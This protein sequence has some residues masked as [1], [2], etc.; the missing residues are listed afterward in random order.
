MAIQL[1]ND[2]KNYPSPGFQEAM[3][4]IY[5][6]YQLCVSLCKTAPKTKCQQYQQSTVASL[7]D[8]FFSSYRNDIHTPVNAIFLVPLPQN[9]SR[10]SPHLFVE[11]KFH[12]LG[13]QFFSPSQLFEILWT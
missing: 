8:T 3:G 12:S 5:A 2:S 6:K 10:L 9:Q 13:G 7:H 11:A 1:L 4:M